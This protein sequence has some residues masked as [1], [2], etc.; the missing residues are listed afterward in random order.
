MLSLSLSIN[1]KLH[2]LHFGHVFLYIGF[3]SVKYRTSSR[4]YNS[5]YTTKAEN[6]LV[7]EN[8]QQELVDE[9]RKIFWGQESFMRTFLMISEHLIKYLAGVGGGGAEGTRV[10]PCFFFFGGGVPV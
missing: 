10:K 4:C 5:W 2:V 7:W 1:S 6:F 8:C 3:G 9:P